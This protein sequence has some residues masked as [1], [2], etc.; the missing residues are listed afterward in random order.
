MCRS[1]AD[2]D[3]GL[4]P[5]PAVARHF[6]RPA[7][8]L[9]PRFGPLL[10][11]PRSPPPRL[12]VLGRSLPSSLPLAD[13]PRRSA[14]APYCLV[15]TAWRLHL[16]TVPTHGPPAVVPSSSLVVVIAVVLGQAATCK[17]EA[18]AVP[19]PASNAREHPRHAQGTGLV[20][21]GDFR[22]IIIIRTIW[23]RGWVAGA[24]TSSACF[25]GISHYCLP[26]GTGSVKRDTRSGARRP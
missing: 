14:D 5:E 20:P 4:H 6:C 13:R 3:R 19:E 24:L 2:S 23:P 7:S 8:R 11:Q 10:L 18:R 1:S 15:P 26:S 21:I 25:T 17:R 16:P 12:L 22:L 9:F